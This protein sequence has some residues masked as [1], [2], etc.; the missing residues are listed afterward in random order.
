MSISFLESKENLANIISFIAIFFVVN[1]IIGVGAYMVDKVFNILSFIPFLKT[2]NHIAGGILNLAVGIIFL[3]L[4]IVLLVEFPVLGFVKPYLEQSQIA[5]FLVLIIKLLS[6]LWPEFIK[7]AT[8]LTE[9]V[10]DQVPI[11]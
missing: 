4:V 5:P 11:E 6:P 2:I 9:K 7:N 1:G 8:E 10:I 3:G